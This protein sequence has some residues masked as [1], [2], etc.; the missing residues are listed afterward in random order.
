MT[1]E[2]LDASMF[3]L[4]IHHSL[5]AVWTWQE[6]RMGN[7]NVCAM[8]ETPVTASEVVQGSQKPPCP[9]MLGRHHAGRDTD[10]QAMLRHSG[11]GHLRAS[12]A[13]F[14]SLPGPWLRREPKVG[15]SLSSTSLP[16]PPQAPGSPSAPPA[17]EQQEAA[18]QRGFRLR[19]PTSHPTSLLRSCDPSMSLHRSEL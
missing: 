8:S 12:S 3:V 14:S 6:T 1:A 18:R 13:S 16:S 5:L 2:K 15:R 4:I 19:D 17:Q 9:A 11:P 7:G 10:T